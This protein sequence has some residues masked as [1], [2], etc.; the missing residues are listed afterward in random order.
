M[1]DTDPD[2]PTLDD[3][4]IDRGLVASDWP[5]VFSVLIDRLGLERAESEPIEGRGT[6]WNCGP[7]NTEMG[8]LK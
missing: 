7:P 3:V 8:K 4:T 5:A 2:F 6:P 1:G